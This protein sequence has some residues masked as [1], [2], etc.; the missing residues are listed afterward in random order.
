MVM[1][2]DLQLTSTPFYAQK[3]APFLSTLIPHCKARHFVS[4][5]NEREYAICSTL[6]RQATDRFDNSLFKHKIA[7]PANILHCCHIDGKANVPI[8]AQ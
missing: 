4:A 6:C 5:L 1:F 7:A 2:M 8:N 3:L